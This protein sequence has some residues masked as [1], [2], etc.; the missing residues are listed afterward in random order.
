MPVSGRKFCRLLER[1]GWRLIRINGSHH[2]YG[3]PGEDD[4]VSVPVHGNKSLT[5]RMEH[6]LAKAAKLNLR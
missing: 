2:I 4:P 3:K 6:R 1:D 5:K